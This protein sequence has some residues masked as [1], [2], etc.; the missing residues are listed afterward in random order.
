MWIFQTVQDKE[1]SFLSTL[2]R[3]RYDVATQTLFYR[4][5]QWVVN[6]TSLR[7][8]KSEIGRLQ[9]VKF[10]RLRDD[11]NQ[12]SSRCCKSDVFCE[13][14][15]RCPGVVVITTT[16][17]HSTKSELRFYTG[18]NP[19]RRVSEICD[20]E[21]L[22]QWSRLEIRRKRLWSVNRSV[23]TIYHHHLHHYVETFLRQPEDV[24]KTSVSAGYMTHV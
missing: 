7:R 4:G 22:W 10:G 18:S 17:L 16:Q 2:Y 12:T 13:T 11:I 23:K 5:L 24:L 9:D 8:R 21:N 1:I 20:G 3:H 6:Q 19:A 14:S 15:W